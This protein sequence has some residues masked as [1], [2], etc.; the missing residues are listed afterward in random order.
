MVA[1]RA[2][3]WPVLLFMAVRGRVAGWGS[4]GCCMV[5]FCGLSSFCFIDFLPNNNYLVYLQT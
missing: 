3:I 4:D 1:L 2:F 5:V